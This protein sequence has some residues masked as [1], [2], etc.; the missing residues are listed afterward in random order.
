MHSDVP[1]NGAGSALFGWLLAMLG[2]DV[3][4]PVPE[5][6]ARALAG[7]LCSRAESA[8]ARVVCG[9]AATGINVRGGRARGVRLAD[10][11]VLTARRA[12]L[13][14]VPAPTLYGGLVA[15]EDLPARL[16]HDIARFD[17]DDATLKL[18]WALDRPIP[19]RAAG[20]RGAG[21]VH[22]GVDDDGLVDVAADLSVGGCRSDRSSS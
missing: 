8:G 10:G 20:A 18:N 11:R 9:V 15:A 14:D 17:W 5:G 22:L 12:V 19:W 3:G 1:P 2:Q 7:A 4:F 6:G 21:T 13:A 16:R